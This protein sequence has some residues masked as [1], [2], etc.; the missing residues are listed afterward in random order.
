MDII[1]GQLGRVR[2]YKLLNKY[3]RREGS[4][5]EFLARI[6]SGEIGVKFIIT[7]GD[8]SDILFK[9]YKWERSIRP[10]L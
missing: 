9:Y 1:R 8:P 10:T 7:D 3:V 5:I 2:S 6:D 4:L